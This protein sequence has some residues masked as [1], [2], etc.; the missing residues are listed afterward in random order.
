MNVHVGVKV[1]Y[2]PRLMNRFFSINFHSYV[3]VFISKLKIF[4]TIPIYIE[5][6]KKFLLLLITFVTV[7]TDLMKDILPV[8]S[9]YYHWGKYKFQVRLALPQ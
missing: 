4:S 7:K 5:V 6:S 8:V 1:A 3:Y 2:R 9:N